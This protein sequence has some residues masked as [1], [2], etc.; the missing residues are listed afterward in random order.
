[1]KEKFDNLDFIKIKIFPL[2][3]TFKK[4]Q[5]SSHRL[6]RKY[7]QTMYLLNKKWGKC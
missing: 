3:E 6:K 1:M 2:K 4:N 5:R 7:L